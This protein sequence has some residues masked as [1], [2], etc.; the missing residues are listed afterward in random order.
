MPGQQTGHGQH[1]RQQR[2]GEQGRDDDPGL[3]LTGAGGLLRFPLQQLLAATAGRALRQLGAKAERLD[4]LAQGG[5]RLHPGYQHDTGLLDGEV[6]VG[7]DDAGQRCQHLVQAGRATGTGHAG[8]LKQYG[9]AAVVVTLRLYALQHR[10]QTVGTGKVD[11]GLL[12]CEV[13]GGLYPLQLVE[14]GRDAAGAVGA[15]HAAER[16]LQM[17]R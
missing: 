14:G 12:Q 1:A 10:R 5:G 9:L 8:D 3:R 13:D 11:G 6:D 15:A 17:N 16:Q 4:L 7:R 2:Q